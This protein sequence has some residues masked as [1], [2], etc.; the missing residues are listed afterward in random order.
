M[1]AAPCLLEDSGGAHAWSAAD[2][3]LFGEA[4]D[5]GMPYVSER[6]RRLFPPSPEAATSTQRSIS[7]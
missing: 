2:V 1:S 3:D 4:T 5:D 7:S 6:S